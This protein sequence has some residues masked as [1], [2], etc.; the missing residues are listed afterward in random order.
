MSIDLEFDIQIFDNFFQ[1]IHPLRD[2]KKVRTTD[3]FMIFHLTVF[4]QLQFRKFYYFQ[5]LIAFYWY[6]HDKKKMAHQFVNNY[7]VYLSSINIRKKIVLE[8]KRISLIR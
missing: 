1:Y 5:I 3:R 8:N 2:K 6:E 7:R 4:I